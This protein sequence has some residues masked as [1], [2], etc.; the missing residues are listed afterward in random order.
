[1]YWCEPLK[2]QAYAECG[3]TCHGKCQM[4]APQDC[5][6][7][8]VKL[9][10]KKSKKKKKGKDGE[11]DDDEDV[12][13]GNGSLQR[14]STSSSIPPSV[15]STPSM[16]TPQRTST[17]SSLR[18]SRPVKH[19][20]GAPPPEKY[21]S[22]TITKP[23]AANG[24]ITQK[25]KVLYKYDASSGEELSVKPNDILTVVEPDDGSGWILART[26]RDEGLVPA[27]YVEIQA[28]T[29]PKKGPPVVPRR[30]GKKTEE[31]KKHFTAL[32]DYDAVTELE[33]T[34]REGDM[35]VLVNEDKGDG[36]TEVDFKGKI[37]SVPSNY[38][39]AQDKP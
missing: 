17:V 18:Q 14:T 23:P 21:V 13:F 32:Y 15:T 1:M 27:S 31:K 9:E 28:E 25:A 2:M 24:G 7:V 11:E 35:L 19:L 29:Q 20:S 34:I 12:S 10:A 33:L 22:P 26:G 36:W 6:G 4:K 8:N 16:N 30:G 39:E 5:T 38:I 37:G 3:Y